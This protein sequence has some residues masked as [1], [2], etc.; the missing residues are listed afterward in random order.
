MPTNE[1]IT[2]YNKVQLKGKITKVFPINSKAIKI[3]VT[4]TR[5]NQGI[6]YNDYIETI[7]WDTANKD[8]NIGDVISLEG[9]LR[10]NN[11]TNKEGQKLYSYQV[12]VNSSHNFTIEKKDNSLSAN[13]NAENIP[14]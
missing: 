7:I 3:I 6:Q 9:N 4:T 8:I 14:F 5:E 13:T 11:Y 1:I 12:M 2:T 10:N